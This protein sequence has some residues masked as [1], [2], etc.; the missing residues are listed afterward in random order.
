[1]K[2]RILVSEIVDLQ[3]LDRCEILRVDQMPGRI[4]TRFVFQRIHDH[5]ARRAHQLRV[6][7]RDDDAV[8]KLQRRRKIPGFILQGPC[9]AEYRPVADGHSRL[10]HHHFLFLQLLGIAKL[11]NHPVS[12]GEIPAYDFLSCSFG[13]RFFV[14][15][16]E[17]GHVDPH[18]CGGGIGTASINLTEHL[19]EHGIDLH[20]AV[21]IHRDFPV[22]LLVPGIDHVYVVEIRCGCLICEIHGM[23][24][25]Q[26]PDRKCFILCVPRFDPPPVFMVELGQTG[27]HLAGTRSR[28]RDHH[29][30]SGGLD[31]I[32]FA[33]SI[34]GQDMICIRGISGNPVMV[35]QRNALLLQFCFQPRSRFLV[36][37]VCQ[38]DAADIQSCLS[39]FVDQTQHILLISNPQ[40]LPYFVGSDVLRVDD[41]HDFGLVLELEQHLELGIRCEARKNPACVIVIKQFATELQIQ[42]IAEFINA[43]PDMF[44]LHLQIFFIIESCFHFVPLPGNPCTFR[45]ILPRKKQAFE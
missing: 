12:G 40:I 15:D 5:G 11:G 14:I 23:I 27:C 7:S 4:D 16:A 26:V 1:M 25:R 6:F 28:S 18:I 31:I 20:I 22:G 3:P 44:R 29:E 13:H 45:N 30:R 39:E 32:V 36:T 2:T 43:L 41:S 42:L 35:I 19:P 37:G 34:L 38:D 21:V 17:A 24:Q 8:F 10:L 9:P 33:K